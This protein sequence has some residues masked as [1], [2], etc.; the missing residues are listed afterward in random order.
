MSALEELLRMGATVTFT[1]RILV[2]SF[3]FPAFEPVLQVHAIKDR[4]EWA[5]MVHD[6]DGELEG[7]TQQALA[8]MQRAF[9]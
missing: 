2:G 8:A 9:K 1:R 4:K 5:G 7:L 6:V 3:D